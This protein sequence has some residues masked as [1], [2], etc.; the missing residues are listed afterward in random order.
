MIRAFM[1]KISTIRA[2]SHGFL[3]DFIIVTLSKSLTVNT[4]I[5]HTIT[6]PYMA[7]TS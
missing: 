5:P 6:T 7:V 4:Y 3:L 1:S 2:E